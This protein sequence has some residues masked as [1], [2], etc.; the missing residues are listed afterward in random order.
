MFPFVAHMNFEA[1]TTGE[2]DSEVDTQSKLNIRHWA[3][4]ARHGA[5]LELPYHGAYAMHID[6][7]GGTAA[8]Y[9]QEDDLFDLTADQTLHIRFYVYAKGLV[10]ATSDRFNIFAL[11]S[12]ADTNEVAVGI[13]NNAGEIQLICSETG[14][15]A[16]GAGSRQAYLEQGVWHCVELAVNIDAGG[17]NDGTVDFY[18]DGYQVGAQI[19]GLDQAAIVHARLGVTGIDAGTTAGHLLFDSLVADDTRVFPVRHRFGEQQM[20]FKSGHLF[21][22]RGELEQVTLMAG[23][24]TDNAL[25]LYDTDEANT[26][27]PSNIIVPELRN[28]QGAS[29]TVVYRVPKGQGWFERGCYASMSGTNPRALVMARRATQGIPALRSFV[30]SRKAHGVV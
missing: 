26:S 13:I 14:A 9:L 24:A 28:A 3:Y 8:A 7:S 30:P 5:R 29:D 2:F 12:A 11:E 23:A 16:V 21:L 10:M 6:L 18:V 22:G 17:G 20:A 4:L 1:G 27:D 25:I 19:T 15:T